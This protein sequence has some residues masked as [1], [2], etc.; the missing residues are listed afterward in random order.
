MCFAAHRCRRHCLGELLGIA[1][2]STGYVPPCPIQTPWGAL[3][4]AHREKKLLFGGNLSE[5]R[6]ETGCP[7]ASEQPLRGAGEGKFVMCSGEGRAS[8]QPHPGCSSA[9]AESQSTSAWYTHR[10]GCKNPGPRCSGA[11][12]RHIGVKC[13]SSK[14]QMSSMEENVW[15]YLL[16]ASCCPSST[17]VAIRPITRV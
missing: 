14:I 6:K 11:F 7:L 12:S 4:Q 16:E 15:F 17:L 1:S 13:I 9:P 2:D 10:G 3:H 8:H 5:P